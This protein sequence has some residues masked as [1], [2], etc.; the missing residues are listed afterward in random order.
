MVTLK[1][2]DGLLC[3]EDSEGPDCR[4]GSVS[5]Y[6]QHGQ[7]TQRHGISFTRTR[8]HYPNGPEVDRALTFNLDHSV[9]AV[10]PFT[11]VA[12]DHR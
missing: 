9:G 11:V 5:A 12:M 4:P 10:Q 8:K 2:G 6:L 3:S 1:L 7:A